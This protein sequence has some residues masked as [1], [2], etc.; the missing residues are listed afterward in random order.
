MRRLTSAVSMILAAATLAAQQ[1]VLKSGIEMGNIDPAVRA[2]DDFYRHINGKWLAR[3][4]IPADK[5]LY[6]AFSQLADKAEADM[7]T[8]IEAAAANPAKQPGS[9]AQMVGDLY[10]SFMN[11]A[12][13][14]QLGATPA[15]AQL[16]KIDVITNLDGVATMAG[17][18]SSINAGGP[19]NVGIDADAKNP[20][21][22]I[23]YMQQGGTALP[24]RDYYLVNDPKFVEIRA[25]YQEFLEKIFTLT[26]RPNAAADAKAVLEF[27][28]ALAKIQWTRVE[29]RDMLK[30]INKFALESLQREMPGFNWMAWARPQGLDRAVDVIVWQ[31]SFFKSFASMA[32]STPLSTWKAWLAAQY[33]TASAPYLSKP[34]VDASFELFGKT[35]SGQPVLRERW[36]RAISLVNTNMGMPVGKLYVEKTFPPDAKARMEKMVANLVEAYRQS[37]TSL[38]WMTAETKT[39]ALEKLSKFGNK[40]GYPD[41]W[42]DYTGLVVRPDDL[43]GN[44]QRAQKFENDYQV[45]KLNK[46]VDRTEWEMTPQTVNAYYTPVRNEIVFPAAILQAPFFDFSADDAAN[47]G[48]IGAVIGHEIG[49]GFDDQGRRF[50]GTGALKD[51]WTE[52]DEREFQKRAKMLVAQYN[53]VSPLP[54]MPVNGELTL[55]ENIG[56]LGGLAISYKAYKLSLGGR[57]AP[58]IDGLTGEQRLFASW[59]QVWRA[60]VREPEAR[61]RLV[62]DTHS[63]PEFRANIPLTNVPGWYEAFGVKPGD[64]MYRDPK[65]RVQIW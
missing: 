48:G 34:F 23:V 53:S 64:K 46:P 9:V 54:G 57:P 15:Q 20:A 58:T 30:T 32:A 47:Y 52:A 60:K 16:R 63:P 5:P 26:N 18:L 37:I 29:S 55:G 43:V 45:A 1:P 38:D 42:R 17:E 24:D 14:D 11:E 22:P 61:R 19:V 41:K 7:R 50:D 44:V 27:E 8:I 36:K 12:R 35:I 4:E 49:H 62:A 56:D 39:K 10:A 28:T 21:M 51:W 33:I 59:A 40:I 6:G 25:K 65:D 13:V 2:Q 3:T 31:P